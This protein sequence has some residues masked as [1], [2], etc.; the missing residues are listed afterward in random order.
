MG[1]NLTNCA[2]KLHFVRLYEQWD[3]RTIGA[4]VDT[5]S[6]YTLRHVLPSR[7]VLGGQ[8]GKGDPIP[9]GERPYFHTL[10]NLL[11][12]CSIMLHL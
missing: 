4:R 5:S 9:M 3:D 10:T 1:S 11:G 12:P 6:H 8:G 2:G 7:T